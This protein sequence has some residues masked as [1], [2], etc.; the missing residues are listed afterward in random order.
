MSNALSSMMN[1][2][3]RP[4]MKK[5]VTTLSISKKSS[6]ALGVMSKTKLPGIL[7][8]NVS[9]INISTNTNTTKTDFSKK[10]YASL[11]NFVDC[12]DDE[13]SIEIG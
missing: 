10:K 13:N 9:M 7:S 2:N 11:M 4:R 1:P 8:Q 3:D 5:K 6:G 12:V